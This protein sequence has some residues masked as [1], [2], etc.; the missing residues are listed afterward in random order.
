MQTVSTEREGLATIPQAMD[1]LQLGRTMV[2]DLI[3]RGVLKTVHFGRAVRLK[4]T[5]ITDLAERGLSA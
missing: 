5:E 1:Y 4:W 3:E 2:Y